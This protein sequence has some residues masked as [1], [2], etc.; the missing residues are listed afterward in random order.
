[1]QKR[2]R[3]DHWRD[4]LDVCL[5]VLVKLALGTLARARLTGNCSLKLPPH[6][7]SQS[8]QLGGTGGEGLG[9]ANWKQNGRIHPCHVSFSFRPF[10]LAGAQQKQRC[11]KE[12][13]ER[14]DGV[15]KARNVCEWAGRCMTRQAQDDRA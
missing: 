7:V 4:G 12:A 6:G 13:V 9:I 8:G 5:V 15:A 2:K 14:S 3:A 11:Q 1:M 10:F